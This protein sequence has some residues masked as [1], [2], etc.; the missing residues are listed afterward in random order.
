[1]KSYLRR[2]ITDSS[3]HAMQS[4]KIEILQ[5]YEIMTVKQTSYAH[6]PLYVFVN[7]QVWL[8]QILM[9]ICLYGSI[10]HWNNI[11]IT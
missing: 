7:D 6:A 10:R 8:F 1:M 2:Y 11:N 3:I 4:T 5:S 9:K